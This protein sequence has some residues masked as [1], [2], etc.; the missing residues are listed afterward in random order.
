MIFHRVRVLQINSSEPIL[1][2]WSKYLTL[3]MSNLKLINSDKMIHLPECYL[4]L[5]ALSN[6]AFVMQDVLYY[7]I[8]CYPT[9]IEQLFQFLRKF[10]SSEPNIPYSLLY[11]KLV[12]SRSSN[13]LYPLLFGVSCKF[14]QDVASFQAFISIKDR[15]Q[16]GIILAISLMAVARSLQGHVVKA[17]LQTLSKASV[18]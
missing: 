7:A 6:P 14:K 18:S 2:S 11:L 13:L 10:S 3:W 12:A 9:V 4:W 5:F 15:F 8:N 16:E 1:I 17:N